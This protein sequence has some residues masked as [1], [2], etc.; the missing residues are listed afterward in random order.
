MTASRSE[1][2]LLQL[3]ERTFLKPWVLSG[4]AYKAGKEI[5][6]LVIPFGDDVIIVSD[7]APDY[8][9]ADGPDLAWSRWARTAVEG[10]LL[11]LG[12]A[13]RRLDMPGVKV[14]T[15]PGARNPLGFPLPPIE[16]RRYHLVAI[17][18]PSRDPTAL[19][20]GWRGL[21]YN[22]ASTPG[23]FELGPLGVRGSFVHLFDGETIDLLLQR[24]DTV[25]DFLAYLTTRAAALGS[26]QGFHFLEPDLLAH[27]TINWM[28]GRG[29]VIDGSGPT[30]SRRLPG[31]WESYSASD[32][33]RETQEKD[34]PSRLIDNLIETF[35]DEFLAAEARGGHPDADNHETT[36]RMLASESRL[37]RRMIVATLSALLDEPNQAIY[38]SNTIASPST[39]GVRYVLLTCPRPPGLADAE[40]DRN[41]LQELSN[42]II[43]AAD[44]FR[45]DFIVG[46]AF[47]NRASNDPISMVR[48]LDARDWSERDQA[49]VA[50]L[51]AAGMKGYGEGVRTLHI[52]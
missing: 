30:L 42:H 19:P 4:P 29:H 34:R 33:A 17:A 50:A 26:G 2:Y 7:K 9:I 28:Q 12:G 52:P 25:T 49:L 23:P 43:L 41:H 11:Q 35:H 6:D 47:G 24:L 38:W 36:M 40:V 44:H 46:M 32:R 27:A 51:R 5:S 48:V 13:V 8:D 15:D 18:R 14:F 45:D 37:A 39:P 21:G 22:D 3:A 31:L 1:A 20:A 16:R 10:S